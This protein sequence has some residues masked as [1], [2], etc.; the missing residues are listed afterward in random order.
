MI[1]NLEEKVAIVRSSTSLA[2]SGRKEKQAIDCAWYTKLEMAK[3]TLI[4][5]HVP[6]TVP[7]KT[8]C[9]KVRNIAVVMPNAFLVAIVCSEQHVLNNEE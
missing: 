7:I 2:I 5:I 4:A 3:I 1:E 6:S 8:T 9:S